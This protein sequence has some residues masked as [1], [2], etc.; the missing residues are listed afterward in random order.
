MNAKTVLLAFY[1]CRMPDGMR[2]FNDDGSPNHDVV[3]TGIDMTRRQPL[4]NIV[5]TTNDNNLS[6]SKMCKV[7]RQ[8]YLRNKDDFTHE[9]YGKLLD[10]IRRI[11]VTANQTRHFVIHEDD[12]TLIEKSMPFVPHTAE[13]DLEACAM[14][15]MRAGA[16]VATETD[17][18]MLRLVDA[19]ETYHV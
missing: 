6:F 1:A 14:Q 3:E 18:C 2:A 7:M 11:Y 10:T 17:I 9:A 15:T 16:F 8:S 13:T 5:F 19:T 4:L 12:D